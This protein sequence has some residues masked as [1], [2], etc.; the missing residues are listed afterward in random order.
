MRENLCC[1]T[2]IRCALDAR[3]RPLHCHHEKTV[4]DVVLVEKGL[5]EAPECIGGEAE[6]MEDQQKLP[7]RAELRKNVQPEPL[8]AA[9]WDTTGVQSR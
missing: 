6:C 5:G 7:E 1:G 2:K 3:E 9:V 4:A 8:S